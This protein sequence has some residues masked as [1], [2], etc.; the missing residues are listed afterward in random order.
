MNQNW[1][2]K[3]DVDGVPSRMYME[4]IDGAYV[5]CDSR[6]CWQHLSDP[7]CW[8]AFDPK[9]QILN[10]AKR[11]KS[12]FSIPRRWKTA[13]AAMKAVDAEIPLKKDKS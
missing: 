9:D 1:T 4:R 6:P 5:W 11:G 13:D 7:R 8:L 3:H 10:K 2:E 12:Q